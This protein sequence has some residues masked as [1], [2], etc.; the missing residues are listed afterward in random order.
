ML[1][2]R[3]IPSRYF[4]PQEANELVPTVR[5]YMLALREHGQALLDIARALDANIDPE[6]R[7]NLEAEQADRELG[8]GH[9]LERLGDLGAEL[10]DPLEMGRIRFP[11]VRNGEP[12]W[13]IW[14]L[15]D[16]KIERWAPI[17]AR[18]F[19]PRPVDERTP[20]R[21]EWRN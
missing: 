7:V 18:V 19:G 9:L 13:L 8:Q 14:N 15:G 20:V 16:A 17:G 10:M 4:T 5:A 3:S 12:V 2:P 11:A 6:T 21:W 1:N